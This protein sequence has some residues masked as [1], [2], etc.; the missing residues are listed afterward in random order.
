MKLV[1]IESGR[2]TW[3]FPV[4]E[5]FPLGAADAPSIIMAIAQRYHFTH[6]PQNPTREDVDKNGL[7]FSGGHLLRGDERINIV[8]FVVYNDGLV[9]AATTTEGADAFLDDVIQYLVN[10]FEFRE[11]TSDVRKIPM[12]SVVVEFS[13]PLSM[14]LSP[15]DQLS[16]IVGEQLNRSEEVDRPIE[17]TRLDLSL[18]TDPEFRP[19]NIPKLTI[20]K[21]ANTP[22]SQHRYYSSAPIP[23]AAH[24]QLLQ[25]IEL[26]LT[27]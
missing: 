14:A 15:V 9:V 3:L 11:L 17:L 7:R 21:R 25:A 4:E 2:T 1:T 12:S 18:N 24:L 26:S 5:F 13:V 22:F 20:E 23:T 6:P 10:E 8:D 16:R 27:R 19:A